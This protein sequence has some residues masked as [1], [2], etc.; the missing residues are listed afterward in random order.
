MTE[1]TYMTV[2]T[3]STT[4]PNTPASGVQPRP[5]CFTGINGNSQNFGLNVWP[6]AIFAL[7]QGPQE[8]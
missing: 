4:N 1:I 6:I 8:S 2:I 5:Q 3:N 7:S